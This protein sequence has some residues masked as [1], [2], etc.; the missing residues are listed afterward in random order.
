MKAFVD[1]LLARRLRPILVA[2]AAMP[3]VPIVSA[4]IIALET[5]RSGV[6]ATLPVAA[7]GAGLLVFLWVVVGPLIGLDALYMS[8]YAG[9][10]VAVFVIGIGLGALMR[11]AGRLALA[12]EA[13]LVLGAAGVLVLN[14]FGPGGSELFSPLF[15][16]L[17]EA[18]SAQQNVTEEQIEQFRQAQPLVLG[19][20]AAGA[21]TTLVLSLFLTY[22]LCGIAV[23]EARFGAEFRELRLSRVIGIP[24]TVLVTASL[25]LRAPLVQ[26]LTALALVGF[27]FQGLSVLHAWAHARRWHSA[28]IVPV[29][30]LLFLTPLRGLVV[31]ALAAA[32]LMDNWFDLRAP[33]RPRT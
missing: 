10:A 28:Y 15:D 29:Y 31:L 3:L 27:L 11:W 9:V 2:G 14:L 20:V 26:N 23:G 33:L 17:V 24:A 13:I 32:G 25:V 6:G 8:I 18:V 1:W 12:F 19:L 5:V 16:R 4:A 22:W 21:V 7:L 30:L